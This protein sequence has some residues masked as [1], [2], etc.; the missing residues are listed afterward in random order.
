MSLS[1]CLH[2]MFASKALHLSPVPK[3]NL[4]RSLGPFIDPS[5]HSGSVQHQSLLE[6]C[7]DFAGTGDLLNIFQNKCP[8]KGHP[9]MDFLHILL[10]IDS[11]S[12]SLNK[13][14]KANLPNILLVYHPSVIDQWPAL[15]NCISRR[16]TL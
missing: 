14:L 7:F 9:L 2:R 12:K 15:K 10:V 3:K 16:C 6:A 8:R 13:K 4:W 11:V 5:T 1:I